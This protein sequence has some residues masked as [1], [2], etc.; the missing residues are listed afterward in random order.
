MTC[1]QVRENSVSE[2]Y[3]AGR[4]SE[5]QRQEFEDHFAA[6]DE[7]FAAVET[8]SAVKDALQSR[9]RPPV[10]KPAATWRWVLA[11]AAGLAVVAIALQVARLRQAPVLSR[12]AVNRYTELAEFNPPPWNPVRVRSAETAADSAFKHAMETYPRHDWPACVAGLSRLAAENGA[13]LAARFYLGICRLETHDP[14]AAA[15][16]L[17][18]VIGAGDTP[19][20]EEAHFYRAK[21]LLAQGDAAAARAELQKTVA[22]HGDLERQAG[23]LLARIR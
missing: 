23:D 3:L 7:C 20:L 12:P 8:L 22:L 6:C 10:R 14:A 21:A 15:T 11:A 1:E 4:L 2:K 9:P 19:Y 16:A 18:A 17:S 5:P 13:P